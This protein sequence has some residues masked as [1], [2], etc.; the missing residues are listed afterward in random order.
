[1]PITLFYIR[2][3]QS[4]KALQ[5]TYVTSR[6]VPQIKTSFIHSRPSLV[7][8][9]SALRSELVSDQAHVLG[10]LKFFCKILNGQ[11]QV[12]IAQI[13]DALRNKLFP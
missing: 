10:I 4:T 9:A 8:K 3:Y 5:W 2:A 7:L 1:M 13:L 11:E 12:F 6:P